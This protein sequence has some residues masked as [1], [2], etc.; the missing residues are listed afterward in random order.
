MKTLLIEIRNPKALNL[1]LC[2][3]EIGVIKIVKPDDAPQAEQ[4]LSEELKG[5]LSMGEN[6]EAF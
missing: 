4:T 2:L 3:E 1:L 6:D 5:N